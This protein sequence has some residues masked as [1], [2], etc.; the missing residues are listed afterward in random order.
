MKKIVYLILTTLIIGSCS[1]GKKALEEGNYLE[2]IEKAVDRL[3]SDPDNRKARNVLSEGYPMAMEYY[4]EEIDQALSGNDRFKWGKTLGIME[5]VNHASDLIRR[6]PAAR[7]IISFP[8]TYTSELS[9]ARERAAE[10]RY[11]AGVSSLERPTREDAKEAYYHFREADR[12]VSSYKDALSKMFEAKERATLNVIIEPIPVPSRRY[13][14]SA[15][16]FYTQVIDRMNQRFPAESFVN[17]YTPEEAEKGELKYPDMVVAL[18]FLDFYVGRPNHFEEEQTLTRDIENKV[19]VK[20]GRDSVRY[21]TTTVR[22]RGKIRIVTDE[23]T[24]G[25]LMNVKVEEFQAEKMLL[26]DQV[27]GEFIWKNQYGIFVGDEEVLTD[28]HKRILSNNAV[29]PPGPQDLFIEFTRP[30]YVRLTDRLSSFF[31]RYN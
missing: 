7:K 26:D 18:E 8:K 23:V 22:K 17:F 24:S 2:A 1:S 11:Q 15:E 29:P 25:G 30:I 13:E 16:F 27:P 12:L 6:V 20:V 14:L 10:E 19:E 28:D 31:R 4:Q 3:S 21:E 9:N 5:R